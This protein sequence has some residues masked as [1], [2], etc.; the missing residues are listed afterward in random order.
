ME[1]KRLPSGLT[2]VSFKARFTQPILTTRLVVFPWSAEIWLSI[3]LRLV[4]EAVFPDNDHASRYAEPS[5]LAGQAV[6][7]TGLRRCLVKCHDRAVCAI[8]PDELRHLPC[9]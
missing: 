7:T 8:C 9:D 3:G 4:P 1:T 2:V 6:R 5:M